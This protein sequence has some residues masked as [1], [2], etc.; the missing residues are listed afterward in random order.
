VC[1]Y[2]FIYYVFFKSL[3]LYSVGVCGGGGG[4]WGW[5]EHVVDT[6]GIL[7]FNLDR[8]IRVEDYF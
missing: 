8:L 7:F 1:F 5:G 2:L 6:S 3:Y 4:G